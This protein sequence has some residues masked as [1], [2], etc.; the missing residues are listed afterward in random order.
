MRIPRKKQPTP[1]VPLEWLNL[2]PEKRMRFWFS[3]AHEVRRKGIKKSDHEKVS[4]VAHQVHT[5][6]DW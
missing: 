1:H 2:H 4:H 3:I 5:K 6:G